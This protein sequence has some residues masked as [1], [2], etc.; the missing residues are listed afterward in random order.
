M[1]HGVICKNCTYFSSIEDMETF[2][3]VR[4]GVTAVFLLVT[5]TFIDFPRVSPR[6]PPSLESIA[7]HLFTCPTSFL[8]YSL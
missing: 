3:H 2:L 8:H 4:S 7:R 1:A 5:V 6:P